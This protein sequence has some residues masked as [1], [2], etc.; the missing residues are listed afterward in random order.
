MARFLGVE[1]RAF[2]AYGRGTAE[3]LIEALVL[4]VAGVRPALLDESLRGDLHRL[5]LAFE[6][7]LDDMS[8]AGQPSAEKIRETARHAIWAAR[9]LVGAARTVVME[10]VPHEG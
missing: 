1:V 3:W 9:R 7:R 2:N 4:P 6:L 8:G 5:R 10:A